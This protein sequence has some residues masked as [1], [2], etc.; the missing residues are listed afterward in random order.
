MRAVVDSKK[1]MFFRCLIENGDLVTVH[2]TFLPEGTAEGDVLNVQFSRDEEA[3][4]RQR[5]LM[6]QYK[7]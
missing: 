7:G 5:E 4:R 2:K 6:Q 1:G 3:T